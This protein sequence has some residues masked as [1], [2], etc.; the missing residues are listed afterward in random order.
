AYWRIAVRVLSAL[1]LAFVAFAHQPLSFPP[2]GHDLSA[3]AFPDGSVAVLCQDDADGKGEPHHAASTDCVACRIASGFDLPP[4]I[5]PA[6]S[7][8]E[9]VAQ[10]FALPRQAAI[11]LATFPPS[12]PPQAPPAA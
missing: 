9:F 12:A 8:I 11:V 10:P 1:A 2:P 7:D 5:L 6:A 3:H 4:R